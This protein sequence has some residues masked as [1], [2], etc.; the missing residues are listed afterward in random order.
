MTPFVGKQF[1]VTAAGIHADGV[2]KNEEIYNIFDTGKLLNRP[3]GV[4]VTDKAGAAGVAFWINKQLELEGA[5]RLDKK[6]EAIQAMTAGWRNSIWMV[7]QPAYRTQSCLEPHSNFCRTGFHQASKDIYISVAVVVI[8][9]MVEMFF[10]RT[11]EQLYLSA[12]PFADSQSEGAFPN[13]WS[14]LCTP[15]N[16]PLQPA[17]AH[18]RGDFHQ[19]WPQPQGAFPAS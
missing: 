3:L 19:R 1:N 10:D 12:A 13:L 17:R 18:L 11:T 16:Y 5:D 15:S 9:Q 14:P 4:Q 8:N 6:H 7:G 2:I